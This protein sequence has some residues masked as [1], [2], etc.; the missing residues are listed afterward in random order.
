MERPWLQTA[1]RLMTK[2]ARPTSKSWATYS[3]NRAGAR[4]DSPGAATV[5]ND[6]SICRDGAIDNELHFRLVRRV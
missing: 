3:G 2:S 4:M 6:H 1:M 5:R